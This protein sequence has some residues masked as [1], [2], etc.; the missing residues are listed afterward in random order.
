MHRYH[1][2][3]LMTPFLP[4][5]HDGKTLILSSAKIFKLVSLKNSSKK[6][7]GTTWSWSLSKIVV[8]GRI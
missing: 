3:G 1:L 5:Y 7:F 8:T 4:L 2:L 6:P